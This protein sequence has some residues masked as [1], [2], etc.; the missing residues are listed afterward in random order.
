MSYNWKFVSKALLDPQ[1]FPAYP[2]QGVGGGGG[3]GMESAE[4][5]P[6]EHAPGSTHPMVPTMKMSMQLPRAR[7]T[8]SSSRFLENE[9]RVTFN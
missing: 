6:S 4:Y 7:L 8:K 5:G 9:Q 3:K 1:F 2:R